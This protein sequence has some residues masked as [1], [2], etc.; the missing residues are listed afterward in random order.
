MRLIVPGRV[1]VQPTPWSSAYACVRACA[2]ARVR[3]RA[4]VRA[5]AF[6]FGFV[7]ACVRARHLVAPA[8]ALGHLA[9]PC[10]TRRDAGALTRAAASGKHSPRGSTRRRGQKQRRGSFSDSA[11]EDWRGWIRSKR[12]GKSRRGR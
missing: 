4:C 7:R 3:V 5:C 11:V 12:G 10:A 2:R 8:L 9:Q 1:R 6:A